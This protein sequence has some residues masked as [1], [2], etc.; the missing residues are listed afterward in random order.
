MLR[1]AARPSSARAAVPTPAELRY[2]PTS[3]ALATRSR[4]ST[5]KGEEMVAQESVAVGR[6]SNE[7]FGKPL[8]QR[9]RRNN[10]EKT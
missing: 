8:V 1:T 4:Q 6:I 2:S 9:E 7:T 3:T 5:G 10:G